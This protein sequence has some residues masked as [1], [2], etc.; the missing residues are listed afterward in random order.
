MDEIKPVTLDLPGDYTFGLDQAK[1]KDFSVLLVKKE[2]VNLQASLWLK[3][4]DIKVFQVRMNRY[5]I[6]IYNGDVE[7][8][9]P[10][11]LDTDTFYMNP[12]VSHEFL[13][14]SVLLKQ[15]LINRLASD[16]EKNKLTIKLLAYLNEDGDETLVK[17]F[18]SIPLEN[19]NFTPTYGFTIGWNIGL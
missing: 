19:I 16:P 17:E 2:N 5:K 18:K 14:V 6:G 11:V 13:E 8:I 12:L 3:E 1:G 15:D 4:P 9:E 10:L 7:Y